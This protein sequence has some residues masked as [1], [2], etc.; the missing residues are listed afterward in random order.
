MLA[1]GNSEPK[2]FKSECSDDQKGQEMSQTDFFAF[3]VKSMAQLYAAQGMTIRNVNPNLGEDYPHFWMESRNGKL[4]YVFV[5]AAIFPDHAS[6]HGTDARFHEFA[7]IAREHNA[8]PTIA[9][10]SAFCFESMGAPAVYGGSFAF[11]FDGLE[12]VSQV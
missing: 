3:V 11:K 2:V 5:N 10:V 6:A 1:D 12:G 4:Y 8:I 9:N 7:R